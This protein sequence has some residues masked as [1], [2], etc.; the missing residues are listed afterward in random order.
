MIKNKLCCS[1]EGCDFFLAT[2]A[3]DGS[4]SIKHHGLYIAFEGGILRITCPNC[5]TRNFVCSEEY[6][7]L[8]AL[9]V[10]DMTA[11]HDVVEISKKKWIPKK[12]FKKE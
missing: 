1:N 5:G 3:G 4:L 2:E 6:A 9:R 7:R 8:H 12:E 11:P 10:K